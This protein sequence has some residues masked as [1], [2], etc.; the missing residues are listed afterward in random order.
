MDQLNKIIDI[1]GKFLSLSVPLVV[2]IINCGRYPK[3]GDDYKSREPKG[4]E[5]MRTIPAAA[6]VLTTLQAQAYVRSLPKREPASFKKLFPDA[7]AQ[8]MKDIAT[9]NHV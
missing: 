5:K 4:L 6:T 3:R 2:L 9:E 7:D 1:L 8:G